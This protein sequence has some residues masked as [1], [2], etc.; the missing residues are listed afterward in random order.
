MDFIPSK[1][2]KS[3][4]YNTNLKKRLAEQQEEETSLLGM[5]GKT[6]QDLRMTTGQLI[7]NYNKFFDKEG[8]E[9][10]RQ[11]QNTI[12][13]IEDILNETSIE[14]VNDPNVYLSL[15]RNPGIRRLVIELFK[16]RLRQMG[17]PEKSITEDVE[18][19][20]VTDA[21][22]AI[23]LASILLTSEIN[24]TYQYSASEDDLNR[25]LNGLK[26]HYIKKTKL[27]GKHFRKTKYSRKRKTKRRHSTRRKTRRKRRTRRK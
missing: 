6:G 5:I 27:G 4:E 9:I 19:E 2:D 21:S 24:L 25:Y 17:R 1:Q 16:L 20:N 3:Y 7:A 23:V 13:D 11:F 14:D 12:V 10:S 18:E 15:A 22:I 26:K 8:P